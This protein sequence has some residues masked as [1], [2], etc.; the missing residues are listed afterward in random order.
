M[1]LDIMDMNDFLNFAQVLGISL[2]IS[3]SIL[4]NKDIFKNIIKDIINIQDV[5]KIFL[6][7]IEYFLDDIVEHL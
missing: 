6:D 2:R 7:M 4:K 5:L 3:L 1:S